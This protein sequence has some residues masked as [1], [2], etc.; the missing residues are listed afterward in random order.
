[1]GMTPS[2][3]WCLRA[4]SN[5][6]HG[7]FQSPALPTELQRRTVRRKPPDYQRRKLLYIISGA[8]STPFSEI[9]GVSSKIFFW[10][11]LPV[12]SAP[13]AEGCADNFQA[14]TDLW[15]NGHLCLFCLPG[16]T[17]FQEFI[18]SAFL[19]QHTVRAKL[20]NTVRNRLH[21]FMVM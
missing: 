1:M 5:H 12:E 18:I 7:D 4:E 6:R 13:S 2:Q 11:R 17:E 16:G 15:H 21:K 8:V 14:K 10:P 3:E 9:F 20:N 19:I